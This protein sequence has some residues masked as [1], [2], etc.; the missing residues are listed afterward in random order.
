MLEKLTRCS[1]KHPLGALIVFVVTLSC[2]RMLLATRY[3]L[4]PDEAHYWLWSR[5]LDW[6]YF[7]KGPVVAWLIAAG[8]ALGGHTELGVRLPA[9]LLSG[10]TIVL[11]FLLAKRVCDLNTA[12]A[13]SL[14]GVLVPMY[15]FGS[16]VMTIDVPS[17]FFWT[18]AALFSWSAWRHNKALCWIATGLC[19]GLGFLAKF[20]NALQG[21]CLAALLLGSS[22]GRRQLTTP[23]PWLGALVAL[24]CTLPYWIWNAQNNWVTW[25]HLLSRG[26]LSVGEQ[27]R[28]SFSFRPTEF[29]TF[30]LLQAVVVSPLLWGLI[31]TALISTAAKI[32]AVLR[33]STAVSLKSD[34]E[35]SGRFFLIC[36]SLPLLAFF[37]FFAL[38]DAGQ[39]NWTAPGYV[40]AGI[41]TANW[42]LKNWTQSVLV[43]RISVLGLL[44]AAVITTALHDTRPFRLSPDIDPLSRVRGWDQLSKIVLTAKQ[45]TGA[46]IILAN[47]YG[48]V[49]ALNWHLPG[50]R[51]DLRVYRSKAPGVVTDQFSLWPSYHHRTGEDAI[52]VMQLRADQLGRRIRPTRSLREQFESWE[53]LG[54]PFWIEQD[55]LKVAPYAI[56]L[57]RKL[58]PIRSE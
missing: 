49:S 37:G 18:A 58:K 5:F 1:N 53:P 13:V 14:A 11:T 44:V 12:W 22:E 9:V 35:L 45:A 3:P 39:P 38:N 43:R 19:V 7:S 36:H 29:L 56:F 47:H 31:V 48:L 46:E 41:L 57:M 40:T 30:L 26:Q 28:I 33:S 16:I 21:L 52:L 32:L 25:D 34:L 23:W 54:D 2:L 42:L 15:A 50:P 20:T 4:S 24:L 10:A 51:G 17:V 6:F 27:E 55:G 8:T